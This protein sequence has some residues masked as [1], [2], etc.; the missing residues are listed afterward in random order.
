MSLD[1]ILSLFTNQNKYLAHIIVKGVNDNFDPI[2]LFYSLLNKHHKKL[3]S[4]LSASEKDAA[5]CLYAIKPG[6]MSKSDRVAEL[7]LELFGTLENS[8]SWFVS[9][10]SKC[11]NS[12]LLGYTRHINLRSVFWNSLINLVSK[13]VV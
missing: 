2:I 13:H 1:N 4:L 12:F 6:F 7:T 3:V 10:D 9:I 8:Y 5:A 11:I